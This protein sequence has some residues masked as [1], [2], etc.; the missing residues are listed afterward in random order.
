VLGTGLIGASIGM[1][2]RSADD[3]VIG[4]DPDAANLDRARDRGAID[5]AAPSAAA[6]IADVDVVVLA[7]PAGAVTDLVA[8][9]D[10]G[11]LVTDVA[12][13]KAPIVAAAGG[14]ARFVG[15]H[16]MAGREQGGADAA[17]AALFRGAVW[18]FTTDG[19]SVDDLEE[20][21]RLAT[22]LGARPVTMTAAEHDR[23]VAVISH[24]PQVLAAALLE[25]AARTPH[26]MDLAAGS[27]R[28]LTRVAASDPATWVDVLSANAEWL[29]AAAAG[30]AARAT[31]V[32]AAAAES[33]RDQIARTLQRARNARQA[34]AAP[35]VPVAVA[36]EDR[37]GELA[38]VGE[39]LSSSGADIR[40]LQL[41]HGIH[42]GGGV[43]TLSVHPGE[44]E[45]LA[46]ALATAGLV[47]LG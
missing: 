14:L 9:L 44:V 45:A 39:A 10:T 23:A 2:L 36:L 20:A 43:L 31:E 38:R 16:P 12:G 6:A 11:A 18:V 30:V 3:H 40:D 33:D 41:R 17:S 29:D 28:D 47:V 8:E 34:L 32:A 1:G 19:A 24:L 13:V 37:P 7:A 27:F 35:V 21:A 4:W 46:E 15:G 42:G 25:E 26:A 22:D 5:A